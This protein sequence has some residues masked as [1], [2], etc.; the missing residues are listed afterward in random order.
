MQL[1]K[2]SVCGVG[3]IIPDW[4]D[5]ES[6][7]ELAL[8]TLKKVDILFGQLE[9]SLAKN[10]H[11]LQMQNYDARRVGPE[12][13][14]ALISTGF[15]VMSFAGNHA[16]DLG[17][18]AFVETIENLKKNNIGVIGAGRNI[19]EARKPF[20]VECKGTRIAFLAY[21]SV[22][23]KGYDAGTNRP[24]CAP[25]RVSTFYEQ[26]DW[27]PG[28]PPRIITIADKNDVASMV[29][30]IANAKLSADVVILSMHWGVHL[31]PAVLAMYQKEVGHAAI[32]AGADLI[33]GHHPHILKAVEVY[34]VKVIF[35][36]IGNFIV[37]SS[38]ERKSYGLDLYNVQVDPEYPHYRY[39]VDARKTII[40]KC[41]ISDKKIERV[42]YFPALINKAV[43]PEVLRRHDKRFEDVLRY[44]DEVSKQQGIETRFSVERDEV[45]VCT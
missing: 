9:V 10:A 33:F 40:A 16:L 34:K 7:F 19:D 32:D 37:P 20:I 29:D 4:P 13:I 18:Q 42:S 8:P 11:G 44:I 17:E 14:S 23:P 3:D 25:I 28:T 6:L 5:P 36:S 31:V 15:D 24:G 39:P 30:D 35:Y 22:L 12:K 43:Q 38:K 45:I 2:V 41:V 27:Q 26:I 21:C 1:A